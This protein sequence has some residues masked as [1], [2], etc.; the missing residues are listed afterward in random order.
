M[1]AT[2]ARPERARRGALRS[3]LAL[4]VGLVVVLVAALLLAIF[5]PSHGR[6]HASAAAVKRYEAAIIGPVKDWGSIEVLGM[7]P[8]V[9]DLF[10]GKDTLPASA[11]VIESRSWQAAFAHDRELIAA[12]RPPTG[13]GRCRGLMLRA[14]D[15]YIE[16]ARGFGHAAQRPLAER[17]PI[18]DAAI[19]NAETGDDLFDQASA[20]LQQARLDA[21]L[22]ISTD[23]PHPSPSAR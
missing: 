15:N 13:L 20:V 5:V 21:G 4:A 1:S 12:V 17:R 3:R 9:R 19:K 23:F 22:G 11:V 10:G 6:D 2:R 18:V 16:A 7:R 14:L 8:S